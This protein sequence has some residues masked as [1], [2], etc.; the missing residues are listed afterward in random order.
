[1]EYK[2]YFDTL[3]QP[4]HIAGGGSTGAI[5]G[6][7]AASLLLKTYNLLEKHDQ[8]LSEKV[9]ENYYNDLLKI[10]D[11]FI[12]A[13]EKDGL[14][15]G[16]VLEAYK[17]PKDDENQAKERYD[18]LQDAYKQSFRSPY[19]IMIN[20]LKLFDFMFRIKDYTSQVTVSELMVAKNQIVACY[21]SSQ[22][23]LR[24]NLEYI[25]DRDF[26]EKI[27]T[28][29]LKIEQSFVYSIKKFDILFIND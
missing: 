9:G 12:D 21:R 11:F 7:M 19:D 2:K 22:V 27:K 13:A 26:I 1:M 5:S 6:A 4:D 10:R 15:F 16:K 28:N 24:L 8:N 18:A 17:L 25:K 20:A 23:N 3:I 29:L 14:A